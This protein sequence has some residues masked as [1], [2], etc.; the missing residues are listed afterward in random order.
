MP[1]ARPPRRLFRGELPEGSPLPLERGATAGGAGGNGG[2]VDVSHRSHSA[3]NAS[4]RSSHVTR[5]GS[6]RPRSRPSRPPSTLAVAVEGTGV[7]V[8]AQQKTA[9]G[10][11]ARTTTTVKSASRFG[12][13]RRASARNGSSTTASGRASVASPPATA[14]STRR[15]RASAS[16][17]AATRSA[18]SVTSM[19]DRAPHA[20]GPLQSSAIAATSAAG[21]DAP[22]ASAARRSRSEEHTSELQSLAYLVCRLLLEKKKQRNEL[23]T[24][25]H[26]DELDES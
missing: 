6:R 5:A 3:P 18:A 2:C 22:Q 21:G 12:V 16:S 8:V 19:P 15:S 14:V 10:R 24:R 20:N 25:C 7:P 1:S 23:A 17:A 13:G 4:G 9:N 26:V 11:S